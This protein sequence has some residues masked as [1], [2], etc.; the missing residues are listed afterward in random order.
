M[1]GRIEP[2]VPA[3]PDRGRRWADRRRTLEA[4]AWK[5]RLVQTAHKQLIKWAVAGTWEQALAAVLARMDHGNTW[6]A[7]KGG[8]RPADTGA[9]NRNGTNADSR[10]LWAIS[11]PREPTERQVW[12]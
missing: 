11:G 7:L 12:R 5:Y 9:E 3:D 10:G 2:L 1:R 6:N 8:L 4:I